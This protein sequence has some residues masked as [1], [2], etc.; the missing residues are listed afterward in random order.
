MFTATQVI[1]PHSSMDVWVHKRGRHMRGNSTRPQKGMKLSGRVTTWMSLGNISSAKENIPKGPE[2]LIPLMKC[3]E[4]AN[5][6]VEGRLVVASGWGRGVGGT[7]NGHRY[8]GMA[9]TGAMTV[10][11]NTVVMVDNGEFIL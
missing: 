2:R 9:S 7:A 6:Q 5:P 3:P 1:N 11:G 10:S 8:P 4:R